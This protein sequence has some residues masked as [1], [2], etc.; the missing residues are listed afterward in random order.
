MK[1]WA[2]FRLT[3]HSHLMCGCRQEV[4][5]KKKKQKKYAETFAR[6]MHFDQSVMDSKREKDNKYNN[7]I[8]PSE[9]QQYLL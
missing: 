1:G 3:K 8:T 4:H 5:P 6:G 7:N 9:N 2:S